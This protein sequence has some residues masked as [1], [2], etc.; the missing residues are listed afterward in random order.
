MYIS[1][2]SYERCNASSFR[3][4]TK[5]YTVLAIPTRARYAGSGINKIIAS[6]IEKYRNQPSTPTAKF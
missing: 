3:V 5:S 2:R 1:I 4:L 6:V